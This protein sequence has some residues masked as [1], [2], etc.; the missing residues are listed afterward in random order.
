MTLDNSKALVKADLEDKIIAISVIGNKENRRALLSVI[1]TTLQ[2]INCSFAK[3]QVTEFIPYENILI[4][5]QDLL[6]LEGM[7]EIEYLVPSLQKKLN[8][9]TLLNGI[10]IRESQVSKILAI[11]KEKLEQESEI[12]HDIENYVYTGLIIF[13]VFSVIVLGIILGT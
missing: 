7:G 6:K 9:K 8:I 11:E 2:T 4:S 10:D 12:E 5:Y 13:V 1:R 3:L